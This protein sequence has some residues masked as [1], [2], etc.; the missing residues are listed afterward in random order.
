[1]IFMRI[2]IEREEETPPMKSRMKRSLLYLFP[3]LII[4]AAVL[5]GC[6]GAR[7]GSV[8]WSLSKDGTLLIRGNG[9]MG[10]V[11]SESDVP[12][13]K[14]RE[15]IRSVVIEEGVTDIP[16][17]AFYRCN[18]LEQVSIAGSVTKIGGSAFGEC[19]ALLDIALPDSLKTIGDGAFQSCEKLENVT[20]PDGITEIEDGVFG[21]CKALTGVKI[22]D[23]VTRIAYN[24]FTHC[25]AL[26]S[27][28]IPDSVAV[29]EEGAFGYCTALTSITIPDSVTSLHRGAF[30]GCTNLDGIDVDPDNPV[31]V[32]LDGVVFTKDLS[33]MQLY[34]TCYMERNKAGLP[35]ALL[36]IPEYVASDESLPRSTLDAAAVLADPD[37]RVVPVDPDGKLRDSFYFLLPEERRSIVQ[38]KT[39]YI[40]LQT[41]RFDERVDYVWSGTTNTANK[42]AF[43][44]ITTVYLCA[45]DGSFAE[46]CRITHQPPPSGMAP[47]YGAEASPE[48]IWGEIAPLFLM[49]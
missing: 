2:V 47:L 35:E 4:I 5:E 30:N 34:P 10:D 18:N 39:D 26:D 15:K 24:A 36:E 31:Y 21:H 6:S 49:S 11:S 28:E 46:V 20:I 9:P 37:V 14:K 22:P 29:I 12:W 44:T 8:K 17:A 40:L 7:W 27:I 33:K 43:D 38:Q 48:E 1:M 41:R 45:P 19:Y 25:K 3:L 32:S 42:R 16:F 23:G 13:Y